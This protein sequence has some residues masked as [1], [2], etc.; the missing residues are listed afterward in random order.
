MFFLVLFGLRQGGILWG[1]CF[2]WGEEL[3]SLSFCSLSGC[4]VAWKAGCAHP[5]PNTYN[6][7]TPDSP[8][9]QGVLSPVDCI[10]SHHLKEF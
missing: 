3:V 6:T 1:L 10:L 4:H 8:L 7:N 2:V 5:T 9:F